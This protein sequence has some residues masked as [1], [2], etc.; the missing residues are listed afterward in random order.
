MDPVSVRV[1]ALASAGWVGAAL[2]AVA[3]G[4]HV[5][6]LARHAAPPLEAVQADFA[7]AESLSERELFRAE[8]RERHAEAERALSL[9]TLLPRS[10]ARVALASGTAL[11]LTGLAKQI[12]L[13]RPELVASAAVG[14][15]G[16]FAGMVVC[17]AFGRQARSLATE[18]RHHWKKVARVADGQWTPGKASG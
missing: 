16:G 15:V 9:A 6:R 17:A 5:R 11:A 14:F 12:P 13:V 8:L 1:L 3:A 18:M 10:L 2:C 7:R 4:F